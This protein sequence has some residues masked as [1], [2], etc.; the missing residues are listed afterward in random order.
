ME[1]ATISLHRESVIGIRER[2][3]FAPEAGQSHR[4]DRWVS[5]YSNVRARSSDPTAAVRQSAGHLQPYEPRPYVNWLQLQTI[6][7]SVDRAGTFRPRKG[8]TWLADR[9]VSD[10]FDYRPRRARPDGD[11]PPE[12]TFTAMTLRA[13]T[14]EGVVDHAGV[15]RPQPKGSFL[16]DR[17]TSDLL[18]L[19][20]KPNYE[21][22][23]PGATH[24]RIRLETLEVRREDDT[25]QPEVGASSLA[26]RWVTDFDNVR[27]KQ[28]TPGM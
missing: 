18:N 12:A 20:D 17:L 3:F 6:D 25:A 24:T 19:R 15:F 23:S 8:G 1:L 16:A 14:V 13:Q 2:Q 4:A 11:R 10:F 28:A 22:H 21:D 7:G 9:W 27:S 5:D 26:D